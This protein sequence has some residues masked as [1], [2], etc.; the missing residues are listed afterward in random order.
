[1]KY[2][3]DIAGVPLLIKEMD[4]RYLFNCIRM[5]QHNAWKQTEFVSKVTVTSLR[6]AQNE[7]IPNVEERLK[8]QREELLRDAEY[9]SMVKEFEKRMRKGISL[10][11]LIIGAKNMRLKCVSPKGSVKELHRESA[12][13][14][15]QAGA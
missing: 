14:D 9:M 4:T 13:L 10:N 3:I 8:Q 15:S 6:D 7:Y 1:M 12:L 2:W 5:C 11:E